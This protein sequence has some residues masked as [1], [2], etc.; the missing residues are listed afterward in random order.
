MKK[1]MICILLLASLVLGCFVGC[2]T[3]TPPSE[4]TGTESQSES[5]TV[6]ETETETETEVEL[7]TKVYYKQED[8]PGV[9]IDISML[10]SRRMD[11]FSITPE[12]FEIFDTEAS[13]K[14]RIPEAVPEDHAIFSAIKD[15]DFDTYSVLA[16]K[17]L[18]CS[19]DTPFLLDELIL[20]EDRLV[21]VF[22]S[23]AREVFTE[24]MFYSLALIL[25]KKT[26]VP[27]QNMEIYICAYMPKGISYPDDWEGFRRGSYYYTEYYDYK[28]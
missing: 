13:L 2:N 7:G 17:T 8:I 4:N 15:V 23:N 21:F 25:V 12:K 27:E 11:G 24:D 22:H 26:D 20:Q 19:A 9:R 18:V 6:S 3:A 10:F 5:E 14:S 16:I 1:R 28:R